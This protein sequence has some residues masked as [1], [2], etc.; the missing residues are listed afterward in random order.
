MIGRSPSRPRDP[1]SIHRIAQ[2]GVS[3]PGGAL[4]YLEPIQRAFGRHDVRH[5]RAYADARA[6]SASRAI[7]AKAYAIGDAVAF[8]EP[9]SLFTAAH[10]A[11]H[12][13]QQRAGVQL[14]GGV[15]E[16]G[17]PYERSANAVAEA[18]VAGRSAEALLDP[19]AP[20]AAAGPGGRA[21]QRLKYYGPDDDYEGDDDSLAEVS[22]AEADYKVSNDWT[23]ALSLANKQ[24][25]YAAEEQINASKLALKTLG[26]N[27][28]LTK[29]PRETF[30][31]NDGWNR[32]DL[33]R[34]HPS[35]TANK[36]G[37]L[38]RKKAGKAQ[39]LTGQGCD[40]TVMTLF[41][42]AQLDMELA[43]EAKGWNPKEESKPRG[44]TREMVQ[45]TAARVLYYWLCNRGH[46]Y[47]G[48]G[49]ARFL[50]LVQ[51]TIKKVGP[52]STNKLAQRRAIDNY[53][54]KK[55][56]SEPAN[57]FNGFF[58]GL[59]RLDTDETPHVWWHVN[60]MIAEDLG[61]NNKIN[62]EV[63]DALITVSGGSDTSMRRA[64]Q[65]AWEESQA[66]G[67]RYRPLGR[68]VYHYAGVAMKSGD[69][70]DYVTLEN[71]ATGGGFADNAS[72]H[73][74]MHGGA[75][76]PYSQSFHAHHAST[77]QHGDSPMTFVAR[78]RKKKATG[79]KKK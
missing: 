71:L 66:S 22:A 36:T 10:E 9:P 15:G 78:K 70:E 6:S 62:P 28:A 52:R 43:D 25:L 49:K 77:L 33:Y 17:D 68:W 29:G 51:S 41:T 55:G 38:Y 59:E 31:F 34:V 8:A 19:H 47:Q 76:S 54:A 12:T 56:K 50:A 32:V 4:P 40:Q 61:T 46:L 20:D 1:A 39:M 23:I 57:F 74:S 27:L 42:G 63:G 79:K 65:E 44:G 5:V 3:G 64:N 14:R 45:A 75:G 24:V 18:V 58:R 37:H 69:G 16:A 73:F 72:W 7:G 2:G 21:V 30:V 13:V 53:F 11:A 67:A 26:A 60:Q 48:M 35:N